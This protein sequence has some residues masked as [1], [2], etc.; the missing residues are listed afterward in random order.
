MSDQSIIFN[1]TYTVTNTETGEYRTF[2]IKTQKPDAKFAPGKRIVSLLNGPNNESDYLGFGF[3]NQDKVS[4]WSKKRGNGKMS[5]FDHF[6]YLLPKAAFSLIGSDG[7]EVRGTFQAYS[8]RKYEVELS[9]R[10]LACNRKLTTPESL[11]RGYGPE[12]S[13]RLGLF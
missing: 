2:K 13:K 5:S 9:K 4:V 3:V 1:G 10:C 12:C 11:R 7:Q 6:A 8:G